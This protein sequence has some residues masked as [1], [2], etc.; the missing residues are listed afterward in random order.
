MGE[1]LPPYAADAHRVRRDFRNI[2][3]KAAWPA[4]APKPTL[5]G[6]GRSLGAKN[7]HP[8]PRDDVGKS[9]RRNKKLTQRELAG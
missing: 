6:P 1:E 9:T 2:R 3:A 4:A 5:P 8:A 7:R